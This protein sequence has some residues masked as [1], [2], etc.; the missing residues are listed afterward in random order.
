MGSA[1]GYEESA[2][3]PEYVVLV[4]NHAGKVWQRALGDVLRK[5]LFLMTSF[6]ASTSHHFSRVPS[7]R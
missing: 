1:G 7:G 5:L 4:N 3:I 2:G 6:F